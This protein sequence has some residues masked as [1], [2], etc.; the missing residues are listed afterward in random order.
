MLDWG[1]PNPSHLHLPNR[2]FVWMM[3]LCTALPLYRKSAIQEKH[4]RKIKK[5]AK[6][7]LTSTSDNSR[8]SHLLLQNLWTNLFLLLDHLLLHSGIQILDH[9]R[10]NQT[11]SQQHI[12]A[13]ARCWRLNG[14]KPNLIHISCISTVLIHEMVSPCSIDNLVVH[15]RNI[16]HIRYFVLKIILPLQNSND[17]TKLTIPFKKQLFNVGKHTSRIR[18]MMSNVT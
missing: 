18:R 8:T 13:I 5:P 14:K 11:E 4:N 9:L 1:K 17:W 16:H 3:L 6:V 12:Q 7:S 15:I 2:L 10:P